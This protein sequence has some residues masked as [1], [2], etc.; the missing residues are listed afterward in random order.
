MAITLL[1][2]LDVNWIPAFL[3]KTGSFV[4]HRYQLFQ[5]SVAIFFQKLTLW[6]I[7]SK[8]SLSCGIA[9]ILD[10]EDVLE[11]DMLVQ[12]L[13]TVPIHSQNLEALLAKHSTLE[14][15]AGGPFFLEKA[16]KLCRLLTEIDGRC[17]LAFRPEL[18][19]RLESLLFQIHRFL[20]HEESDRERYALSLP[21]T[22]LEPVNRTLIQLKDIQWQLQ[23][24]ILENVEKIRLLSP[25]P[26]TVPRVYR[27]YTRLN[28][29]LNM[30][31]RL[32]I[33]GR[34]SSGVGIQVTFS[35]S[36][37]RE[38]FLK[39]NPVLAERCAIADFAS[40]QIRI[41]PQT[42]SISLAFKVAQAVGQLGENGRQL[43]QLISTDSF[44]FSLFSQE[45]TV[46]QIFSHTRWA[47]NGVI[48]EPNC[49]PVDNEV[50][51]YEKNHGDFFGFKNPFYP[52]QTQTHLQAMLNGDIDNYQFLRSQ[53]ETPLYG[54]SPQVSTD[55]KI[56]PLHVEHYLHQGVALK[57][58]FRLA[59]NDFEGSFAIALI[60]DLEPHR[61]YLGVRGSG[62]GLYIGLLR[63]GYNFAS[64]IYGIIE[65]TSQYISLEGQAKNPENPAC[66]EGQIVILDQQSVGGVTAL[67]GYYCDGTPFSSFTVKKAEITTRDIDRQ[68]FEHFFYKEITSAPISVRNTL[69]GRFEI[70]GDEILLNL[71]EEVLP[72]RLEV[73]LQQRKIK[74]IFL[75]GQG[76]ASIAAT[77]VAYLF[78]HYLEG[79]SISIQGLK[80]TEL[81]GWNLPDEMSD[82]LLIAVSQSGTTTDTNR[83][84]DLL[85]KRGAHTACIVN[86][87]NSRITEKVEGVL[88]TSDGRDVEMSVAS[89]KAFYAQVVA[90]ALY[91]LKLAQILGTLSRPKMKTILEQ[92]T[93]L[94]Q[95]MDR[96]LEKQDAI[97]HSAQ[98][99]GL[100]RV[101]WAVVGSGANFIA[102]QEIRIKLSELCYKSISCDL[103]EDKKHIDLSSEPLIFMLASGANETIFKDL[104]KEA[105]IFKA[106]KSL[107]IVVNFEGNTDFD[108]Y[109]TSILRIPPCALE[110]AMI[111]NTMVGHL[112]GYYVAKAINMECLFFREIRSHL[113]RLRALL[114][115]NP[116]NEE[117]LEN[118]QTYFLEYEA[119]FWKRL[120]QKRLHSSLSLQTGIELSQIFHWLAGGTSF[121]SLQKIFQA[122]LNSPLQALDYAIQIFNQAI[123]D[124]FRPIDAI[125]HQ[126]KTVTVGT[127]RLETLPDGF[128]VRELQ[129]LKITA[130]QI[131]FHNRSRL[132]LIQETVEN[133]AGWTFYQIAPLDRLG[134]PTEQTRI[135]IVQREG[136]SKSI[137]SRIQQDSR[138]QGTKAYVVHHKLFTVCVGQRDKRFIAILPIQPQGIA[139]DF[140]LLF[141]LELKKNIS[142]R[143]KVQLLQKF[144]KFEEVKTI[145]EELGV[146]WKEEY[147]DTFP[148]QYLFSVTPTL[149]A[150]EIVSQQKRLAI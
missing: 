150:H 58:A 59:F 57:D 104:V 22:I 54:I 98:Q 36:N 25:A 139:V 21:F 13:E 82:C 74:K 117:I 38:Q 80:A 127:S 27:Q 85:S 135:S 12:E 106:H 4:S 123:E 11:I 95:L 28:A 3:Q 132:K 50:Y 34:D 41:L 81:S 53:L 87:R 134:N 143:Q 114:V 129:K 86:R 92:W 47:S 146:E 78:Q 96:L 88:F 102:A 147:L 73:A 99:Y 64:E 45:N 32:E 16:Q 42:N 20:T 1:G 24:D 37:Q 70:R 33:R 94:P 9:G 30:L 10:F 137:S 31:D 93:E 14:H 138:L 107:P 113:G 112:W 84:V 7:R 120:K 100:T 2:V 75:V 66:P 121:E 15:Y 116:E 110:Q 68:N 97:R 63:K 55:A 140:L 8:T 145:C 44:L 39:K 60:S 79:T 148:L 35:S 77:A 128:M 65:E 61:V 133:V 142:A 136:I 46:I 126:A 108:A 130:E 119:E 149:L 90:G 144:E 141:H 51:S 122:S 6:N 26:L 56:I 111:L 91:G 23:H 17:Q 105:G 124:L 49:H 131:N 52:Q 109:A 72:K 18:Q 69:R 115:E 89:T 125:K 29:V 83:A 76:T 19:Q 103:V 67:Q 40:Q 71:G 118:A 43:R 5:E 48:S 101:N 62:Q